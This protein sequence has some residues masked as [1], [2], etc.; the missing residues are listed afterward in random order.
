MNEDLAEAW[1]GLSKKEGNFTWESGQQLSNETKAHWLAGSPDD[2]AGGNR[3]CVIFTTQK[4]KIEDIPCTSA[5]PFVCQKL[6]PG[7]QCI[8]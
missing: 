3:D 2:S 8:I 5:K 7:N 1:V 4:Q 6:I